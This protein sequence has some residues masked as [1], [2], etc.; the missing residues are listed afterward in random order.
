M[1]LLC[2]VTTVRSAKPGTCRSLTEP[3]LV[4]GDGTKSASTRSHSPSSSLQP[5]RLSVWLR[6][7]IL[8]DR[9]L[10]SFD[11]TF[12][13]GYPSLL[14][15]VVLPFFTSKDLEQRIC[16]DLIINCPSSL[17]VMHQT[18]R[19][20]DKTSPYYDRQSSVIG[21]CRRRSAVWIL[22]TRMINRDHASGIDV[23]GTGKVCTVLPE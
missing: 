13:P 6:N 17:T 12:K 1:V 21:N 20:K 10:R 19:F 3:I 4:V 2:S 7:L 23:G 22:E 15:K 11:V 14:Q 9:Q 16:W 8:V 5:Y 18:K